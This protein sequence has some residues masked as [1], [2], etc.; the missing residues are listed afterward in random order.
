MI[1]RLGRNMAAGGPAVRSS[2]HLGR[3]RRCE[4]RPAVRSRRS[5]PPACRRPR[6]RGDFPGAVNAVRRRRHGLLRPAHTAPASPKQRKHH[7]HQDLRGRPP[8]G[9]VATRRSRHEGLRL[10]HGH[11]GR[12]G[13]L[14]GEPQGR[15][16]LRPHRPPGRQGRQGG[17]GRRARRP[18]SRLPARTPP[19][20]SRRPPPPRRPRRPPAPRMPPRR[21]RP[22]PRSPSPARPSRWQPAPA[23]NCWTARASSSRT[24]PW[25]ATSSSSPSG[26]SRRS[27][28][29]RPTGTACRSSRWLTRCVA[30]HHHAGRQRHVGRAP[31]RPQGTRLVQGMRQ[32][33][34]VSAG[35][36]EAEGGASV[37]PSA[38][39][40]L[41][42]STG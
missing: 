26:S 29:P 35:G 34:Q 33:G 18:R 21:R 42:G 4:R 8:N 2:V 28:S 37:P 19:W 3:S 23:A 22:P 7:E 11:R 32:G 30:R 41:T 1:L 6:L 14:V 9:E 16:G 36:G 13:A 27:R 5:R 40:P 25:P 12:R 17:R 38:C 15:R 39:V 10:R 20:P 24:A 31:G